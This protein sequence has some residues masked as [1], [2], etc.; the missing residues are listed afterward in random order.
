MVMPTSSV[1]SQK[2][3][4]VFFQKNTFFNL[5]KQKKRVF[6]FKRVKVLRNF[7]AFSYSE[8]L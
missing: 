1:V 3:R 7:A 5:R 8:H 2:K 4:V 6:L